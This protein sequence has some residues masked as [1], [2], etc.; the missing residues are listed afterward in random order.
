MH[1]I[2]YTDRGVSQRLGGGE[3]EVVG[4]GGGGGAVAHPRHLHQPHGRA[5]EGGEEQADAVDA[6][7][8]GAPAAPQQLFL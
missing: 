6:G 7:P 2:L 8:R 1:K 3:R 5:V 4:G